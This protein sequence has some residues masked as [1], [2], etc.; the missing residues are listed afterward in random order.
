MYFDEENNSIPLDSEDSPESN[1]YP[2]IIQNINVENVRV[3]AANEL[4][5]IDLQL[6]K[7]N[8]LDNF[9]DLQ[10]IGS[11]IPALVEAGLPQDLQSIE[12]EL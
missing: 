11:T 9:K 7:I 5:K 2:L 10:Y 3:K 12:T 8:K 6:E 1:N 4:K